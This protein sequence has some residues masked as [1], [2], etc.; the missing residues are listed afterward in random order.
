MT[1]GS[2]QPLGHS[3]RYSAD[4]ACMHCDGI[5]RHETWCATL[6]EAAGYAFGAI[7]DSNRLSVEDELRLH[8][9]GVAW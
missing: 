5:I 4:S 9:L 8:A 2:E 3:N 7:S 1:M 6:S